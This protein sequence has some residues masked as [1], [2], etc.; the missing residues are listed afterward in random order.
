MCAAHT[1]TGTREPQELYDNLC[2]TV[3]QLPVDLPSIVLID[4]V[5]A[6]GAHLRAA[7]AYLVDCRETVLAAVCAGRADNTGR[8]IAEP[9]RIRTDSFPDFVGMHLP[10]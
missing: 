7:A 4:D 3:R 1:G 10:G 9:F 5:V 6:T 8:P 2:L